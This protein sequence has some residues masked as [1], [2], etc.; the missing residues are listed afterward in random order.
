MKGKR[1]G[2]SHPNSFH[3]VMKRKGSRELDETLFTMVMK[4]K[5]SVGLHPYPFHRDYEREKRVGTLFKT[6][7]AAT[8]WTSS[9]Q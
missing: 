9:T 4:G 2:E 7:S 8:Y 3:Q 1:S 5:R 6:T